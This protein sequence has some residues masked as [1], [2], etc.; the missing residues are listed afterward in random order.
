MMNASR[1]IYKVAQIFRFP[2]NGQ[3]VEENPPHFCWKTE[4]TKEVYRVAIKDG[5]D[6][7]VAEVTTEKSYAISPIDL[8]AGNYS[9]N[10]YTNTDEMGWVSF[11]MAKDTVSFKRPTGREIYDKVPT[12]HP[13][14]LFFKED[15]E[16]I[17]ANK[18]GE[19]EVLK[20]N[21]KL[22]IEDGMPDAP[23]HH[24]PGHENDK[25]DYRA[26][27]GRY[28]D[29]CD[30]NLVA[31]ALGHAILGDEEAGQY[32]R[33]LL[34]TICNWNPSGPCSINGPWGDEIG[35]S[36]CRCLPSVYDLI[37]DILT[38]KERIFVERTL[39][40]YGTQ[41]NENFAI[42]DFLQNPG[43]SH[44]GR[45]PAYL[46]EIAMIL[47]GSPVANDE[48]LASW[49][50][51]SVDIYG[52]FFPHYGGQDGGWAES[53]FYSS[54]YTKWYLPFF[55]AVERLAGYRF[56]DRP[57]YQRLTH[58]FMHFCPPNWENHPFGDGYWCKSEDKE[59]PGFF[60]QNP[61]RFYAQRFGPE[62]IQ[63]W[64][65]ELPLPEIFRLHLLDIF[66][67]EGTPPE[68]H[69][70]GDVTSSYHFKVAGVLSHHTNIHEPENDIALIAR[71]S[72]YGSV[73]HQHA[74][75]GNF[76][77]ICD[78]TTLVGP[79]G[80]F[81]YEFGT[82]H[83]REWTNQ[84]KAH[85]CILVD[86]VGQKSFSHEATGQILQCEDLVD[87][88]FAAK[89]DLSKAYPMLEHYIR[90]ISM[91]EDGKIVV[92]D[93]ILAKDDVEISWLLHSLS[94]PEISEGCLTINRNG[95]TLKV[96]PKSGVDGN[97]NVT[98]EF[99]TP[100]DFGKPENRPLWQEF[101]KQYHI[102]WKT[103]KQK[104]HKIQVELQVVK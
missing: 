23:I 32:A 24:M 83:H 73:S 102:T 66:I 50:Q 14:H 1:G 29:I 19:L 57:F 86:G 67:P 80:Y 58:F 7:I 43:H 76:A 70:T 49:L 87:G 47:K 40:I 52:S 75:Q 39:Y 30:R 51:C 5:S 22:A 99:E 2:E 21:I 78:G 103:N 85:N 54:T 9:W 20:R 61:Y 65:K 8:P 94:E 79:S 101:D 18:A 11:E 10:L 38:E 95:K 45:I 34:L 35:L 69:L 91:T 62:L 46:G 59:W 44:S 25:I 84:T 68:K 74:D 36:N 100:V 28:R 37:W 41:I 104:E 89:M 92:T 16:K 72:R 77:I 4:D 64:T 96:M 48:E 90:D 17:K 60:A 15:I 26:F 55:M 93:D 98:D 33:E 63:K 88:T 6:K 3:L 97:A 31:C 12:M 71:A 82:A 13:R 56:L 81:G 53:V 27:F 42:R